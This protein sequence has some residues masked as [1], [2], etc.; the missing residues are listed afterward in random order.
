MAYSYLL[1]LMW[2]NIAKRLSIITMPVLL[3]SYLCNE[4]KYSVYIWGNGHYQARPDAL[5][6][7]QNYYPKK[8]ANLPNNI[9]SLFFGEFY[10]AGIDKKGQLF[11]WSKKE[12]DANYDERV[13]DNERENIKMIQTEIQCVRFT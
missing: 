5:L 2:R 11:V 8:I 13:K 7:F 10:E 4:P 6:Q 1:S 12:I 9:V 3:G